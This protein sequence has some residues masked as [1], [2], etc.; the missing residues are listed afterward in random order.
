[1]S[2]PNAARPLPSDQRQLALSAMS[3]EQRSVDSRIYGVNHDD[4][5][6]G[7]P[8]V[9]GLNGVV[10]SLAVMEWMV[11]VTELRD[12]IPILEYRGHLGPVFAN[13]DS[14]QA[15]CYYRSLW[16]EEAP[17]RLSSSSLVAPR[18]ELAEHLAPT[19]SSG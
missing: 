8:S 9:V 15:D 4:L 3:D 7:G 13:Q 12:P 17:N 1:M 14:P 18:T 5:S 16:S 19:G 6:D 2:V 11:W 10:A